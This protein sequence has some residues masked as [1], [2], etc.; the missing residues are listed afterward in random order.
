MLDGEEV[1]EGP[2]TSGAKD[3]NEV[4][5]E[6]LTRNLVALE[7]KFQADC[8]VYVGPIAFGADGEIR[9]AVEAIKLK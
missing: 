1:R 2:M 9:D 5:E 4:V 6:Q 3:V 8:L 7:K